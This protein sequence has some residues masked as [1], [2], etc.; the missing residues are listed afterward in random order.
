MPANEVNAT[1]VA[2]RIPS[3]DFMRGM[4]ILGILLINTE[5]FAYPDSWSPYK[6]G[7]DAPIDRTT[8]FWVYFLTQGKFYS[9]FALLFHG[10]RTNVSINESGCRFFGIRGKRSAP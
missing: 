2:D 1:G 3:L 4:A 9:M 5:T 7:F 8:R 6:Y 10:T